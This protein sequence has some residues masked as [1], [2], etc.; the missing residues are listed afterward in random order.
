[1]LSLCRNSNGTVCDVLVRHQR[2]V[3]IRCLVCHIAYIAQ[4]DCCPNGASLHWRWYRPSR[5]PRLNGCRTQNSLLM[6]REGGPYRPKVA[7]SSQRLISRML[8]TEAANLLRRFVVEVAAAPRAALIRWRMS[9]WMTAGR[10]Q[11]QQ[12]TRGCARVHPVVQKYEYRCTAV[13]VQS[14][15]LRR[16]QYSTAA[17]RR[18]RG[19][20]ERGYQYSNQYS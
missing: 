1:M 20:R 2:Y 13:R 4:T 19:R 6:E 3:L 8:W 5:S 7:V 17:P 18:R 12:L 9:C 10:A 16:Q 15:V 11:Q 14:A